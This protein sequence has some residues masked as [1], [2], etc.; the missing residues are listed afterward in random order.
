MGLSQSKLARIS[1]VTR[2]KIC[3]FEL[4]SGSLSS[5]DQ[6][7]IRLALEAE[8]TRLSSVAAS[9]TFGS[10]EGTESA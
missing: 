7:R 8:A 10:A 9:V 3:T 6:K 2:F 1:G 5:E 4:G